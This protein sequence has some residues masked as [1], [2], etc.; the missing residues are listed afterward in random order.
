MERKKYVVMWKWESEKTVMM[1]SRFP[2][3]VI[4]HMERKI[5]NVRGCD[6]VPLNIPGE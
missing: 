4:K 1:T 5:P 6:L 2:N 3:T